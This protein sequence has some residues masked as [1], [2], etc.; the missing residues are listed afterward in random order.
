MRHD[1]PSECRCRSCSQQGC[2]GCGGSDKYTTVCG[3][4]PP[5]SGGWICEPLLNT[6][7]Q[8][9]LLPAGESPDAAHHLG[10]VKSSAGLEPPAEGIGGVLLPSPDHTV[11]GGDALPPLSPLHEGYADFLSRFPFDVFFTCTFTESYASPARM[12]WDAGKRELVN[13]G[14]H[15]I[16]SNT[17]ALNNFERFLTDINFPGQYFVAAEP[18]FERDVPHLHGLMESCG[19]SLSSLWAAWFKSR[20][21]ANFSV[22][23][24]DA[25]NIYC[26]K[27]T[28][29]TGQWDSVRFR[30]SSIGARQG[31][32]NRG[33]SA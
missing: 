30:M 31:V 6:K 26:A 14:G 11:R 18:H 25:V 7:S 4:L 28:I 22:P 8:S 2:G 19:L 21:R 17:A 29:K 9:P 27:Y 24:S 23:R 3:S 20:G 1:A 32:R 5:R 13:C 12:E 15:T 33:R 10:A 16:Y